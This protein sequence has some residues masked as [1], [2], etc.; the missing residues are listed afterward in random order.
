M[1]ASSHPQ[2]SEAGVAVLKAGGNA[3]DAAL[4]AAA[5]MNMVKP[6]SCGVGGDAWVIIYMAKTDE[7]RAINAS[8]RSPYG[9][10]RDYFV[11][12]GIGEIGAFGWETVSVPGAVA[13]WQMLRDA[14]GTMSLKE[15]LAPAIAMAERLQ[16]SGPPG[17]PGLFRPNEL[18]GTLAAIADGGAEA[19]YHGEIARRIVQYSEQT[20]GFFSLRDF[21]ERTAEWVEP[22]STTN[23]DFTVY[24]CPPPGQGVSVLEM[25]NILEGFDLKALGHN[26]AAYLSLLIETKRLA[27]ADLGNYV[28]D[29]SFRELPLAGMISKQYA[30]AQRQRIV[31]GRALP[32]VEPGNPWAYGSDTAYI[33]AVDRDRNACSFI[34][35]N[36]SGWGSQVAVEGLGII[37]QNRGRGFSL[38]EGHLNVLEPHKRP[39]HTIIPSMM[40]RGGRPVLVFGAVGGHLQPQA[41]IQ[42]L[43]NVVE[44]GMDPQEAIDAP[45]FAHYGGTVYDSGTDTL[46][47]R[48]GRGIPT[49]VRDELAAMGYEVVDQGGFGEPEGIMID[50]DRGIL[51]GGSCSNAAVG[52]DD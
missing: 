43:M 51:L 45:R 40:L 50:Y 34:C 41:Q 7:L 9:L 12:R 32:I 46:R 19:F 35:S 21:A 24:E 47:I 48:L 39:Y 27:F 17:K 37:L 1:V 31:P 8:G 4:A 3:A 33:A 25:L 6:A 36:F 52:Y 2:A 22:I 49:S 15:L 23:R 38:K 26:S 14:Y 44:F 28:A 16:P 20:G 42:V 13:G 30:A 10:S 5:M 18:A 29:P 11:E